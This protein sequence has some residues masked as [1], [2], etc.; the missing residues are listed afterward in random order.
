MRDEAPTDLG[1]ETS[2]E[3][4]IITHID[5]SAGSTGE[6]EEKEDENENDIS[7]DFNLI[8]K[9]YT[10]ICFSLSNARSLSNKIDSLIDMFREKN[11]HFSLITE[12]WFKN[13]KY[14][15]EELEN[16]KNAEE[17][18]F[19]CKHRNKRGGGVAIA[20]N[21]RLANFK[22]LTIRGNK[23]E[24]VGAVGNIK[25]DM[26]KCVVF[27]LYIPPKQTV[28][29][30]SS[31]L[32]CLGDAIEKAKLDYENPYIVIGG[33]MNRRDLGP[34]IEDF[35]D[36]TVAATGAT[37]GSAVLDII[38]TNLTD[39][40]KVDTFLPLETFDSETTSDHLTLIG[41]A[42]QQKFHHYTTT[43]YSTRKYT[44]E[45]EREF[46]NDLLSIDW[47]LVAG[48][49]PT[50]SAAKLD[51]IL[52][53]LFNK[54]FPVKV[55][56]SRSC[57]PPWLTKRIKRAIRNRKREYARTGRSE[58]WKKKRDKCEELIKEA[59]ERYFEKVKEK[60]K[61]AGN[62]KCYFQA[63]NL[64]K[65]VDAPTRW[66][67]QNMYPALSDKEI[68][69]KA[70]SFFNEISQ[71]YAS[72]PCPR[73][74]GGENVACAGGPEMYAI[75]ARLKSMKKP[76]SIVA[77][78]IDPRL[79]GKFADIIA[80]PLHYIFNQ[81]HT[82][83]EWPKLW[84]TETVTMI[85][86]VSSPSSLS[87]LRNI[88]CTPLF[89]KCLESFILDRFKE[90]IKLSRNQFGGIRGTGVSHFLVETWNEILT[91]LEDPNA[92]ISL[93][94]IDFEKA[95]NRMSHSHCIDAL[96]TLGADEDG[97]KLAQAFLYGRTM[98]VKVGSSLSDPRTVPGGSPQGSILGN[99]LF[100]VTT[101]C[102]A[103]NGQHSE[104]NLSITSG[105]TVSFT[106]NGDSLGE[107]DSDE[108]RLASPIA[109]PISTAV[110][111]ADASCSTDELDDSFPVFRFFRKR[112]T[113]LEDTVLS[114][115]C[116]QDEIDM[117]LGIPTGWQDR[118]LSI[119]VYVDDINNIEKIKQS[120]A[121]STF[122][123]NRPELLPHAIKS[124][125]NFIKIKDKAQSMGM[126]VNAAKT[127]LLCISGNNAY[128]VRSYI[129]PT[130]NEEITS[131]DELKI[132]GFW[133][134]TRPNVDV[135]V[136]KLLTK[137]RA[138]LWSLRH[139]KKSGMCSRDLLYV[140]NS[141]LKPVLDFAAPAYHSL[142][143]V[144]QTESLER[145]Q[146]KA[147]SIIYG[148]QFSYLEAMA[149]SNLC[150]LKER[151]EELTKNFALAALKNPRY[152]DGWFPQ[153]P[154]K[155]YDTRMNRP[156]EEDIVR[157]ERM[158]KNPLT[159][160]KRILNDCVSK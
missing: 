127:Q 118:P 74:D 97:V 98:R 115:R 54:H 43:T 76:R 9:K 107:V 120:T 56:K 46:G 134:G 157:T 95:F 109:P 126:Q 66:I 57:D 140:Y 103:E 45:A 15:R 154:P 121:L 32:R 53:H 75:A 149:V 36:I 158:K 124:E 151:R 24:L 112:A 135:H 155:H 83:L 6:E 136:G 62:T 55:I 2:V 142:L 8:Q 125:D 104:N 27:S 153:K 160:M 79:V 37:R 94:S 17:I 129:R 30:T 130:E 31:M 42:R 61:E 71:E 47:G 63:V 22:P 152:S 119:K 96:R 150:T 108:S 34:A 68:A 23:Y 49:T 99:F 48:D 78:D 132:L 82:Q 145:L 12:T 65:S 41:S 73:T 7:T 116:N 58:R 51:L 26:R 88:S 110:V 143:T 86:K 137:F 50:E 64:L 25:D 14:T 35:P 156:Y 90:T 20:F 131:G 1:N 4:D 59:K 5:D 101:N 102:L 148:Q 139:L 40:L 113:T 52:Q 144:T 10:E 87:Q 146:K 147:L 13:N 11:L 39:A 81:V 3:T 105:G 122:T 16:I 117:N 114:E 141:I 70:A 93:M 21:S 29:T 133:F 123:Q 159:Y 67:I 28:E 69:E 44:E 92:A 33:D 91:A 80:I 100:C 72:I 84:S 138:R 111:A 89:S 60:V 77:G 85:P 18:E 128:N 19:I 106:N 38:A